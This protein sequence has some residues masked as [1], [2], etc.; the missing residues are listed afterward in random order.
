MSTRRI[1]TLLCASFALASNAAAQESAPFVVQLRFPARGV[2]LD[3]FAWRTDRGIEVASTSLRQL[4]VVAP[5]DGEHVPLAGVAGLSYEEKAD[6]GAVVISCTMAC[7]QQQRV[8]LG[9]ESHTSQVDASA[10]GGYLN[11][12]VEAQWIDREG[13]GVSGIAEAAAFGRFGLVQSTW[14]GQRSENETRI[15]RLDTTWTVDRPRDGLRARFG[16]SIH[17][18][19]N[20]APVRFGGIQVGRYF[21]LTPSLIT[22]PTP[23]LSGDAQSASTVQLYVDGVLRA[24][25]NVAAGPFVIDN[26][27]VVSGAGETQ[28]V[29]TDVL[30]RQQTITRPF[31]VSTAL[32]RRGL[33]DWS[34]A[35]GAERLQFGREAA[36]YGDTFVAGRYRHGAT[37][38]MTVEGAIEATADQTTAEAGVTVS[39]TILGQ[40]SVS[41]AVNNAGGYT[42]VAWYYDGRALSIGAQFEQR[43]GAFTA[44]GRE[45]DTFRQGLA[46]NAGLDMGNFGAVSLTAAEVRL[47]DEPPARTY[48][49]SYTPDFADGALSFRL[50]Q[51]EHEHREL[52]AGVSF[53]FILADAVSGNASI[54]SDDRGVAYRASAQRAVEPEHLGWRARA[55]LGSVERAEAAV[56]SRNGLGDT[57]LEAAVVDD[58]S[59]L[60]LRHGGSVGWIENTGF[61]GRRIEGAFALVDAGASDVSVA[62][63]QLDAG[64]TGSDGRRLVTNLRPYDRNT[65]SID[66]DD[67]PLDR[68]PRSPVRTVVPSEGA[69]VV[70]HF[71]DARERIIETRVAFADGEAPPRGSILVRKRDGEHFPVGSEGR[72]VLHGAQDGDELQLSNGACSARANEADAAVGLTLECAALS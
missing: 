29:I 61:A 10:S 15:T 57:M 20:G 38:A 44:L 22:Y 12:E 9:Q 35:A 64:E 63:N 26:A 23:A 71:R 37:N 59:G 27:P 25:S 8:D 4:G 2:S 31:F 52:I 62:R 72:I 24:Q 21:G 13:F 18:G 56:M 51:I 41:H 40:A 43:Q 55:S 16:D 36:D 60:R 67:L 7:Y 65:I 50:A 47:D 28:L 39:S 6:E 17:I 11:Y 33:S 48:T 5:D 14:I 58:T 30:G 53:T 1:S 66:A 46:G 19:A 45:N 70:I 69:G 49:L 42:S 54:D 34:F 32:L 68:A 3:A